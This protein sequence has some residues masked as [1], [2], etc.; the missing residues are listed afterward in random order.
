LNPSFDPARSAAD[1]VTR[2]QDH[3]PGTLYM[4][5]TPIG[6]LADI[7]LRSLHVLSLVDVVACEDTRN[8]QALFRALGLDTA[9]PAWL[10][11]HQHNEREAA[12]QVVDRLR[13]GQRVAYLSDAG[14]PGIS[15]PGSRLTRDV[16]TAG[17][18]VL[19]LPGPSS[20]TTLLSAS[21]AWHSERAD[22][23]FAGFMPA[24]S[25]ERVERLQALLEDPR[26]LCL[27]EAP[28]RIAALAQDLSLAGGRG[29]TVGRE[30]SKQFEEIAS[31]RCD[32]FSA[33]LQASPHRVKGEYALVI[34][35]ALSPN[36]SEK[37][38]GLRELHALLPH[39]PLKTAVQIATELSGGSRKALYAAALQA[40]KES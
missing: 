10:G 3:P 17:F 13:Q 26:P 11:V 21:G 2:G 39:L 37:V 18:R 33:W 34:H 6:N 12:Q 8:T 25:Q 27:L 22:F 20:L 15:D 38:I 36:G 32:A 9:R 5:P 29:L 35:E 4:V 7:S 1:A 31:M 24:K 28:H 14:T 30:L 19:P 23:V 16:F 40:Q